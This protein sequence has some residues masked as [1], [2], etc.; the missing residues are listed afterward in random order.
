VWDSKIRSAALPHLSLA[1][2]LIYT[3]TRIGLD[4]TT[5]VDGFAF[6]VLDPNTGNVL[7]QQPKSASILSDPIQT[8]SMVL[9]GN[10]IMQGNITGLGRIG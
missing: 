5:P 6:A 3:I 1:D 10:K 8:S 2:G 4:T 9:M 7:L